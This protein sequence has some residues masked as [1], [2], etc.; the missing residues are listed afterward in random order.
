[1]GGDQLSLNYGSDTLES[2][3]QRLD[4]LGEGTFGTVYKAQDLQTKEFVAL[5]RIAFS[6]E[7]DEG[8]PSTALREVCYLNEV[9]HPNIIKLKDVHSHVGRK[10]G[11]L[12]LVFE[13]MDADLRQFMKQSAYKMCSEPLKRVGKMMLDGLAHLHKHRIIHRDIKPQNVLISWDMQ[14]VKIADFGLARAFSAPV[15]N[16]THEVVTL[17]YRAPE[18]LLGEKRYTASI[19]LWSFGCVF[20]ELAN[21][22]APVFVGDSEI[23]TI[24][25][26]F[27]TIGTPTAF[28]WAGVTS[29][30]YFSAE[31][32]KF[33][34]KPVDHWLSRPTPA[35]EPVD[36]PYFHD[37]LQLIFQYNPH[38]RP[39]VEELQCHPYFGSSSSSSGA[40]GTSSSSSTGAGAGGGGAPGGNAGP[41]GSG[42]N[43]SGAGGGNGGGGGAAHP[44]IG[45]TRAGIGG[46]GG[47]N[48]G[49]SSLQGGNSSS[50]SSTAT[51]GGG[52]GGTASSH[53]QAADGASGS[54][55]NGANSASG[56]GVVAGNGAGGAG[57]GAS[58]NSGRLPRPQQHGATQQMVQ[59]MPN[60][61]ASHVQQQMQWYHAAGLGG[62]IG[63]AVVPG[64]SCHQG[65]GSSTN[66]HQQQG[67][68]HMNVNMNSVV[69]G[70]G[71]GPVG[72]G[73]PP[74]HPG[75]LNNYQQAAGQHGGG[76]VGAGMFGGGVPGQHHVWGN[77]LGMVG[78]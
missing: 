60:P 61:T 6:A 48:G 30:P 3:Y 14:N 2:F 34:G 13:F 15:R 32:P 40:S 78:Q 31:Y 68:H 11:Y 36:L 17:W 62:T 77:A 53:P 37:L 35:C 8:I 47:G 22:G 39:A 12:H 45:Q 1:M 63:S 29:L 66:Q 33:R 76:A 27:K 20:G 24:F 10:G 21:D 55:S 44:S 46:V 54:S 75:S 7:D 74:H 23:G 57:G 73:G 65:Q 16:Y 56:A 38:K 41:G 51:G 49:T 43:S 72:G 67:H 26:I 19:D 25:Q 5:K 50:S 71:G 52:M 42:A 9:S 18:I 59:Q 69:G 64:Q 70:G 4:K 28:D 58:S